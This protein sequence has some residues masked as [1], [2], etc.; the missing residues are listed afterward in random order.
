MPSKSSLFRNDGGRKWCPHEPHECI[1]R[2]HAI[3][4]AES[5]SDELTGSD[6]IVSSI[7]P[8]IMEMHI[9]KLYFNTNFVNLSILNRLFTKKEGKEG[10]FVWTE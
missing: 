2:E 3:R 5:I 8:I 1:I 6:S 7:A 4:I 9:M 10:K